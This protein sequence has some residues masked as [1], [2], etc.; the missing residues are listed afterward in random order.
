NQNVHRFLSGFSIEFAVLRRNWEKQKDPL[1]TSVIK[2]TY[3]DFHRF[4]KDV[5]TLIVAVPHTSKT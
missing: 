4:L 5:D 2:Y 1:P 3:D